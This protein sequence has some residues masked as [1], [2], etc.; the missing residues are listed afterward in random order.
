M[1][2]IGANVNILESNGVSMREQPHCL[3]LVTFLEA[4][5][6]TTLHSHQVFDVT[7]NVTPSTENRLSILIT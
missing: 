7:P 5:E 3:M 4:P 2:M 1:N 6:K